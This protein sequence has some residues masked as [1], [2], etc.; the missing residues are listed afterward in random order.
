MSVPNFY[1]KVVESGTS[2]YTNVTPQNGAS[3]LITAI[4]RGNLDAVVYLI[5]NGIEVDNI[6]V[7]L[8]IVWKKYHI[9][10]YFIE[11][12]IPIYYTGLKAIGEYAYDTGYS[13]YAS[14]I[15]AGEA[16]ETI[17]KDYMDDT[18]MLI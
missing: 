3:L 4:T 9:I 8:A 5:D 18:L 16:A 12:G 2:G 13:M 10:K 15:L 6:A 7:R 17:Y 14:L 11:K 1:N